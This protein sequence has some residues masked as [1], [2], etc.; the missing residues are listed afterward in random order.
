M[1][2]CLGLSGTRE[3]K[4]GGTEMGYE[5]TFKGDKHVLYLDG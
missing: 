5:E 4:K 3:Q 1:C 2:V